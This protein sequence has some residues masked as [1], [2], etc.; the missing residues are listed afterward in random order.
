MTAL[1][2]AYG[3]E[4]FDA[5]VERHRLITSILKKGLQMADNLVISLTSTIAWVGT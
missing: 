5:V 4:G 3:E 1:C 2:E